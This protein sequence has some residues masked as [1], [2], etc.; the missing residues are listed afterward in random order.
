MDKYYQIES[1][2]AFVQKGCKLSL[3]F[4]SDGTIKNII[5]S[6]TEKQPK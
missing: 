1:A 3:V 5:R 4:H 6:C 2:W